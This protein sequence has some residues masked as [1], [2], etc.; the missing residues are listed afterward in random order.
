MLYTVEDMR[1]MDTL[2]I[3]ILRGLENTYLQLQSKCMALFR[4]RD[5]AENM[6]EYFALEKQHEDCRAHAVLFFV[7]MQA[8]KWRA[9]GRL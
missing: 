4:A 3:R 8:L 9:E 5:A 2:N 6:R 1:G 7:E